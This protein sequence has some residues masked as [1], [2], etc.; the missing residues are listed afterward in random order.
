ML[1]LSGNRRASPHTGRGLARHGNEHGPRDFSS[2]QSSPTLG[3]RPWHL[4]APQMGTIGLLTALWTSVSHASRACEFGGIFV[5]QP[6]LLKLRRGGSCFPG[7]RVSDGT[8]ES[9]PLQPKR[10][11]EIRSFQAAVLLRA[12]ARA[13]CT[14]RAGGDGWLARSAAGQLPQTDVSIC[15]DLLI[16]G[17]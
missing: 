17:V 5:S 8:G 15:V 13:F 3:N 9:L 2:P 6:C 4:V 16:H 7:T 10:A 1:S 12:H 11:P 14:V